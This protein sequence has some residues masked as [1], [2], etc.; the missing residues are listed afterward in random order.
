Y[1]IGTMGGSFLAAA[2]DF[3]IVQPNPQDNLKHTSQD[4][5]ASQLSFFHR[6]RWATALTFNL[7]GANWNCAVPGLRYPTYSSRWKFIFSR[8]QSALIYYIVG[9]VVGALTRR[10]PPFQYPPTES[11]SAHGLGWQAVYVVLFWTSMYSRMERA[12]A[13]GS[14]LFVAVGVSEPEDWPS[15]FGRLSEAKSLRSFWGRS[16]HQCMRRSLQPQ[17]KFFAQK[18]LRLPQKSL[19]SRYTQLVTCF[20]LSGLYHATGDWLVQRNPSTVLANICFFTSLGVIIIFEDFFIYIGKWV[21]VYKVPTIVSYAWVLWWMTVSSP[22]TIETMVMANN[23]KVAPGVS[24][25]EMLLER[26]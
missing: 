5:P 20:F 15:Y 13:F 26:L 17:A 6:L 18:I 9:D 11:L 4:K 16:W 12:H 23:Y 7:R 10:I 1:T 19:I 25:V 3:L 21:G 22:L 2:F 14:A 24:V 8:L